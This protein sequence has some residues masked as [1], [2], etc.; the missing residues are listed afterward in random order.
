VDVQ[1][2]AAELPG[3]FDAFPDGAASDRRFAEVLEAVP[4]LAAVNNLAL[5][6]LA[7]SLLGPGE[8]YVELGTFRGTSLIAAM[9]GN[10]GDFVGIDN[11]SMGR[12]DAGLVRS[13]LQRFGLD[14]ATILEGDAFQLLRDG[15]LAGRTVGVFYYDAAH[16]YQAH[17]DGLRLIEPYLADEALLIVDDSDWEQVGQATH[18]Y[19]SEQPRAR[20]LFDVSGQS[21]GRPDWWEGVQ[22][23]AWTR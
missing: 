6:N 21:A 8:S 17:L 10:E 20:M 22:V 23:L 5:L 19:L 2:F 18:D 1:R 16:S 11:F 9:L 12:T 4:G 13:N 3:A 15:A 7:A 14:S